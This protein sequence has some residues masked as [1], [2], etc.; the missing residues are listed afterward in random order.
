MKKLLLI[1]ALLSLSLT[2]NAANIRKQSVKDA[3]AKLHHCPATGLPTA[4]CK[5]FVIDDIVPLDCGGKDVVSNKQWQTIAE[6]KAKD[7]VERN[8]PKCKHRTHGVI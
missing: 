7:K 2:A 5:G 6:G 8:G 1:A 4:S 3:F